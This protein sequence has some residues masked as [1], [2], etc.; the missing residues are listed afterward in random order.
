[1]SY[2]HDLRIKAKKGEKI[3]LYRAVEENI[4]WFRH[5]RQDKDGLKIVSPKDVGFAQDK[6]LWSA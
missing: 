6:L 5:Y 2:S 3:V 1:L 4:T